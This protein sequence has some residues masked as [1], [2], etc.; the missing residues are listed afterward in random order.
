LDTESLKIHKE[1]KEL[2]ARTKNVMKNLGNMYIKTESDHYHQEEK[3]FDPGSLPK[4]EGNKMKT[5]YNISSSTNMNTLNEKLLEKI[6]MIK[7]YEKEIKEKTI[8]ID[9]LQS[10]LDKQYEEI[11][12]LQEKLNVN[13]FYKIDRQRTK[14]QSRNYDFD[15]KI[16]RERR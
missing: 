4:S 6:K 16:K 7:N 2:I 13:N 9:K 8:T 3:P 11:K 15:E 10:K 5:N 12:K 14:F 1:A